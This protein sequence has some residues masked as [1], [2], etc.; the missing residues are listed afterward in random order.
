MTL[1]QAMM[2]FDS[3]NYEVNKDR[4]DGR[5]CFDLML[6]CQKITQV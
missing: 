4:R 6:S 2:F 5:N 1:F 3:S